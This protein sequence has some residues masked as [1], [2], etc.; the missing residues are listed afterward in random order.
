MHALELVLGLLVPVAAL[1]VL[2]R[3]LGIPYP[4]LLVLGGLALGLVPGLPRVE[5]DSEIVFLLFLPPLLYVAAFFTSMRDFRANA[6][7][8][9]QLAVGLVLATTAVVAVVAHA[10]IPGLPWPV[11]FLLG[12]IVS[13][14]DAITATA[15]IQRLG[16]PRRLVTI[17]EGESLINDATA[18]VAYRAALAAALTGSF[19]LGDAG[20]RFAIALGGI[21]VGL[22]VALPI[23]QLRRRINDPPVEIVISL[24][25]PFAAYLP[26]EELGLS[27]VLA[28]VAAGLYLGQ[29]ASSLMEAETRLSG[30][31]V[32]DTL[33]FVLNGLVFILIGLQLPGILAGLAGRGA[34]ELLALG[35]LVSLTVVAVRLVWVGLARLVAALLGG[36]ARA[37]PWPVVLVIGWAGMRGVVSLATALALPTALPSGQPFPERDLLVFLTFCVILVT[38]VGQG[39]SLPWVMRRLGVGG[40][41]SDQIE[42]QQARAAATEA[43]VARIEQLADEWPGH[44]PLIDALRGQ[45]AHRRSHLGESLEPDGAQ[46]DPAAEQELLE[47]RAIRQAIIDAER[48][49]VLELFARGVLHDDIRRRIERDLDLEEVRMEA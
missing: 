23:E 48:R 5:L 30:R 1:A 6:H 18:L 28:A 16:A 10:A 25:T 11:A 14:T 32:W 22:L 47:H 34:A 29:R 21:A 17:L 9:S 38:L 4:I 35:G 26:A 41:G 3:R 13:P 42:E 37:E 31:A 19:S 24:L 2:A 7:A 49:A 33:V 20:L 45:Y 44:L 39:L 15:V 36:A 43:A 12:A 8:I 40:D 27:G 46:A